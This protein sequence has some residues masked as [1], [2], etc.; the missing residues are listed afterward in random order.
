M[1]IAVTAVTR[2]GPGETETGGNMTNRNSVL[3]RSKPSEKLTG[4]ELAALD[5]VTIPP[6]SP[7]PPP[8]QPTKQ[9]AKPPEQKSGG[10]QRKVQRDLLKFRW[11]IEC[12]DCGFKVTGNGQPQ[13]GQRLARCG[14]CKVVLV[15]AGK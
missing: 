3:G 2:T 13:P 15:L 14:R 8:K 6:V 12:P 1:N 11:S 5:K 4:E 10:T 9:P 7:A